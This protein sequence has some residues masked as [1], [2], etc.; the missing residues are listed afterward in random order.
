MRADLVRAARTRAIAKTKRDHKA[1]SA[2]RIA[3][4]P[5]SCAREASRSAGAWSI[6]N[7]PR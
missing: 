7:S 5:E 4:D 2:R 3:A 6:T 1:R